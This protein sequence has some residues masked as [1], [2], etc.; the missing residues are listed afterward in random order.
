MNSISINLNQLSEEPTDNRE[1]LIKEVVE[2]LHMARQTIALAVINQGF[3]AGDLYW[4][5]NFAV[6]TNG[7]LM[8]NSKLVSRKPLEREATLVT[9]SLHHV[10]H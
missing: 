2:R 10:Q 5:E 9:Q 1:Q 6:G 3:K 4:E 7:D 8:F